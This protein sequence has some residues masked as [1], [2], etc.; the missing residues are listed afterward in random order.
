[1]PK[2]RIL[3]PYSTSRMGKTFKKT[4]PLGKQNPLQ[5]L[6]RL[7]RFSKRLLFAV[8][9]RKKWI[10]P[11]LFT[12]HGPDPSSLPLKQHKQ[13]YPRKMHRINF[14]LTR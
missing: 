2:Q 9:A 7:I 1:M 13:I 10:R 3:H 12:H 11:T 14:Q 8:M 5:N 4:A 6:Y